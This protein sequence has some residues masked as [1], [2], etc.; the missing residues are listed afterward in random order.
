[1]TRR[2]NGWGDPGV[3]YPLSAEQLTFLAQRIGPG[4]AQAGATLESVLPTLPASRLAEHPLISTDSELRLRHARGQS[5]PDWVDLRSGR[6]DS[7][8]DGVAFPESA[9]DVKGILQYAKR[10]GAAVIPYGGG[11]S[12]V[13]HIHPLPGARPIVTVDMHRMH[14]LLDVDETAGVASVQAGATG[15]QLEAQLARNGFTL[16]HFPQSWEYSTLG[17]WI[18][19]RSSG[20]QALHYGRMDELLLGGEIET[21]LSSLSMKPVPASASGPDLRQMVLGSEGRLGIVTSAVIKL[22]R[23]A[24]HERFMA[25][26]LPGWDTGLDAVRMCAQRR[27]GL[28]MAR[29]S[30]PRETKLMLILAATPKI[31]DRLMRL[32]GFAANRCLLIYGLTGTRRQVNRAHREMRASLRRFGGLPI[33]GFAGAAWHRDR[34]RSPYLRNTLWEHGYAVDTIETAGLWSHISSLASAIQTAIEDALAEQ[35]ERAL[36]FSHLSHVYSEGAS[37][38]TTIIF[39]IAPDPD[40][41]LSLWHAF[42]AAASAAILQNGGTISHQHGIGLDHLPYL[43]EEIGESGMRVLDS[44]R[45]ELDPDGMMN[46]GKLLA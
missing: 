26:L 18:A 13:G 21:P 14:K 15:P 3:V 4:E 23:H 37:V 24:E 22:Q 31:A 6:L 45:R 29:L 46:P 32:L 12:V 35:G 25:A 28:S 7:F 17:G 27:V 42:K 9:E 8:P 2:W 10:A 11:T 41:T 39:R 19:T 36:A 33:G 34:F 1:M 43:G 40:E 38:Y 5:L 30:D 16:G 44:M 20:Q